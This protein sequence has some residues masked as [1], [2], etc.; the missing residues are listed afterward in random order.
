MGKRIDFL[1]IRCVVHFLAKSLS[2]T[3][4]YMWYETQILAMA[5]KALYDMLLPKV[6]NLIAL[7]LCFTHQVLGTLGHF[8]P[9]NV[10]GGYHTVILNLPVLLSGEKYGCPC[11]YIFFTFSCSGLSFLKNL[12]MTSPPKVNPCH[13][14]SIWASI[15]WHEHWIIWLAYIFIWVLQND[16][17]GL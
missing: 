2:V 6:S 9:A 7:T 5:C 11:F 16:I 14:F 13:L 15:T 10:P 4:L 3:V 17:E 1:K 8:Q 12:F